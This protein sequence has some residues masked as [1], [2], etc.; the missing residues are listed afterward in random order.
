M[1]KTEVI[2]P[3]EYKKIATGAD[4]RRT[5][6]VFFDKARLVS[7]EEE[8]T[9]TINIG[10]RFIVGRHQLEVFVNGQFK[11]AIEEVE[12]SFHGDYY[13][14]SS[15]TI[16][17][18]NDVIFEGD[19]IRFRITWGTYNPMVRP[20]SDLEANLK[21]VAKD[22]F[23]DA[24]QF[25]G[26]GLRSDRVIGY[27]S[28][29]TETPDIRS[30]RTWQIVNYVIIRNLLMGKPDDIRYLIWRTEA[31]IDCNCAIRLQ[32][33]LPFT[34]LAGDT[35]VLMFDGLSWRELTRS[36]NSIEDA[37]FAVPYGWLDALNLASWCN[38][39]PGVW[40]PTFARYESELITVPPGPD[41]DSII[42]L[43]AN[44]G[45]YAEKITIDFS[46]G[47]VPINIKV[48]YVDTSECF[49]PNVEPSE[50]FDLHGE[51]EIDCI[52]FVGHETMQSFFLN[53]LALKLV[54]P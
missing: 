2:T 50:Q 36:I 26:I 45:L 4:F 17:F 44:P 1:P 24:Y 49:F 18:E 19:S 46:G 31:K 54:T 41:G 3:V 22:M 15:Y 20:P 35:M 5:T 12:G 42:Q 29:E 48:K 16:Q 32:G 39:G 37:G 8:T 21:Q 53:G 6:G 28:D 51:R 13:E 30:Y 11:R 10:H 25:N 7:A 23:G 52:E 34:G 43:D 9:K 38:V 27:I 14:I 47:D 40:S 33:D